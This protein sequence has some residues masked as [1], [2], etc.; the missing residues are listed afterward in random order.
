LSYWKCALYALVCCLGSHTLEWP[1]GVVF[2][3][4]TPKLAVGQKAITFYRRAHRTVR[5]PT[6]QALCSVRCMPRQPAVGVCSSRPLDPTVTRV[7]GAH[8][9]VRCYSPTTPFCGPSAQTVRLSHRTIRCAP[10]R[11]CSL[12]DVPP[13]A[14]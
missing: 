7:S 12:S 2:I 11:Y 6:G 14:G 1:V 5:C 8:R 3:A 4:P 10:D 13:G 9:T